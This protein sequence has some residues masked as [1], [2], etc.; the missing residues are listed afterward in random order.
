MGILISRRTMVAGLSFASSAGCADLR[1]RRIVQVNLADR[2]LPSLPTPPIGTPENDV[3]LKTSFDTVRRMTVPVFVNKS[4]PYDFVVDTGANHSVM[5]IERAS[6]L[7]LPSAGQAAVHGIAGVNPAE[8]VMV[9][10]LSV[11]RL[12]SRG[13]R[14]PLLPRQHL[15]AEGLLGVDVLANRRVKLDFRNNSF[16]ISAS[17]GYSTAT[18]GHATR[19]SRRDESSVF[20]VPARQR[21]GQLTIVD[22]EFEGVPVTAFLDSGAEMTVAN[23]ACRNAIVARQPW[24]IPEFLS[25]EVV[26]ATGQSVMGELSRIPPLRLG[27]LK[28]G[29]LVCVF[30]DLHTFRIWD[31]ADKPAI[32]VGVDVMRHFEAVELDFGRREVTFSGPPKQAP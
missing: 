32:L 14:M 23:L 11:G 19:L 8:T 25:V 16:A 24:R 22:A 31:L 17:R 6:E 18:R 13:I 2:P 29:N 30:A 9:R 15:G 27:G 28:I 21:F 26:S 10:N 5:A 20:V 4:G 12:S 7:Q 3:A 1:G